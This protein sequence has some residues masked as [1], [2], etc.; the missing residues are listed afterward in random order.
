MPFIRPNDP[1]LV[2]TID[3]TNLTLAAPL[4]A[5][6]R[7]GRLLRAKTGSTTDGLSAPKFI[8]LNLQNTDSF[9]PAVMH[10]AAYRDTVEESV[11]GG[12]TWNP[13]TLDK[14][15]SDLLLLE[16]CEDNGV[17]L[18]ESRAIYNAVS[19]FGQSSFDQDRK[20]DVSETSSVAPR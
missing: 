20:R 11:D 16:L 15:E 14:A 4:E 13:V 6:T 5:R 10:D 17:P 3:G 19:Y 12:A 2:A 18:G 1:I 9:Q 8:K 7:S